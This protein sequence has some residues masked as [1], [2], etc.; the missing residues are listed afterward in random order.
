MGLIFSLVDWNNTAL[1]V[2]YPW[3]WYHYVTRVKYFRSATQLRSVVCLKELPSSGRVSD[4]QRIFFGISR[5]CP[6]MPPRISSVCLPAFFS[7][8]N[9]NLLVVSFLVL[10]IGVNKQP[11]SPSHLF[12]SQSYNLFRLLFA[13]C[14]SMKAVTE[15]EVLSKCKNNGQVIIL[16]IYGGFLDL[17]GR[18]PANLSICRSAH[19]RVQTKLGRFQNLLQ[20]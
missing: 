17:L 14:T 10:D 11:P 7:R 19:F 4:F 16:L 1:C 8:L 3:S 20:T 9:F 6:M 18:R 2:W 5:L 12:V 15:L 13:S